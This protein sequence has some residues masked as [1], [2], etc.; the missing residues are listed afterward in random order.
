MPNRPIRIPKVIIRY[1][2]IVVRSSRQIVRLADSRVNK[3]K[4]QILVKTMKI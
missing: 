4:S 2:W 3:R 1:I